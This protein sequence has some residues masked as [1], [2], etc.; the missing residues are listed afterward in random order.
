MTVTMKNGFTYQG[1]DAT[2]S[3]GSFNQRRA[4]AE[5]GINDGTIGAYAAVNAI[6]E[7]GW[8]HLARDR[9]KQYYLDLSFHTDSIKSDLSYSRA[10]NR[11]FGQGAAAAKTSL[12][13]RRTTSTTSTR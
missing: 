6:K 4:Q 7:G 5:Y 13:A 9:I 12:P 1:F 2:V 8:R 10:D 3:G 11:L